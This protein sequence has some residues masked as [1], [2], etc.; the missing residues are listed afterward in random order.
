MGRPGSTGRTPAPGRLLSPPWQ[1]RRSSRRGTSGDPTNR[2]AH[3]SFGEAVEIISRA[4]GW[5]VRFSGAPDNYLAAMTSAGRPRDEAVGAV[6]AFEALAAVGDDVPNDDIKQV[7]G[8]A[9]KDFQAYVRDA[10][11]AG[12][13]RNR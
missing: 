6:R 4:T 5:T 11:A 3:A 10:A 13:W 12:T 9:P 1:P 8:R 7:T 2:R